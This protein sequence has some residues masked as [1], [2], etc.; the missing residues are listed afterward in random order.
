MIAILDPLRMPAVSLEA[1]QDILRECALGVA[2][3]RLLVIDGQG[4]ATMLTN[5]DVVIII[6]HDQI[7]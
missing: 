5:G 7:A 4:S 1:L 2:I 6:D 3:C